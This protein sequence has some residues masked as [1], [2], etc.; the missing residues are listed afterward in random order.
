MMV[1]QYVGLGQFTSVER[2]S[3]VVHCEISHNIL[4]L[5]NAPPRSILC[6]LHAQCVSVY[7]TYTIC[8][9]GR[10]ICRLDTFVTLLI[11]RG[12]TIYTT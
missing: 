11:F 7:P 6:T 10:I 2:V 5:Q 9:S 1:L 8:Y 12:Y 4:P 3:S